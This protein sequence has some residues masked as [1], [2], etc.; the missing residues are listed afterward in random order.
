VSWKRCLIDQAFLAN[1]IKGQTMKYER[2]GR[3][4]LITG[5]AT[6]IGF[7][8]AKQAASHGLDIILVAR[9]TELLEQAQ[10][11]I[12]NEFKVKVKIIALD[13]ADE[14][15]MD[16][17]FEE[18]RNLE[19]G[20]LIPNAGCTLGGLFINS[21][22]ENNRKLLRLNIEAPMALTH[23]Y[24][25]LMA[26]KGRG[27]ILLISSRFGYQGVPYV[28]NYSATKAYILSLGEALNEELGKFGVDVTVLSPGLTKTAMTD[29][30][31]IDW[32]KMPAS[33][34]SSDAVAEVGLRALGSQPTV[35]PGFTNKLSIWANRLMPR[36]F[37]V[38]VIGLL[39]RKA[40]NEEKRI[41]LLGLRSK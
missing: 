38:K 2:Y 6:G 24:G 34:M 37:P 9:R 11:I 5:G 20:L 7:A 31:P 21:S 32:K 16:K 41:E 1:I 26:A 22:L 19:V 36:S 27:G 23:H 33:S 30:A 18:T 25:Q 28:A 3:W 17:L 10:A 29:D 8:L 39:L 40:V 13:L 35:V 12:Q 15:S 4:A 14:S